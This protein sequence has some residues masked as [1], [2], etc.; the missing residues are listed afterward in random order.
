MFD[1]MLAQGGSLSVGFWVCHSGIWLVYC[2]S[3][4]VPVGEGG[5]RT[6]YFSLLLTLPLWNTISSSYLR[7]FVHTVPS[8]GKEIL[9]LFCQISKYPFRLHSDNTYS[10]TAS[11][12]Y[13]SLMCIQVAP[14]AYLQNGL[15][16]LSCND[17]CTGMFLP[18]RP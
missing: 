5:S 7:T 14:C 13:M 12:I 15:T 11:Q 10:L 9:S 18:I 17:C 16:M 1:F 2:C 4:V 3:V 6:S 8:L